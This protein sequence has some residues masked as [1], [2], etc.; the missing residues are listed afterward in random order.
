MVQIGHAL[1]EQEFEEEQHHAEHWQDDKQQQ[2]KP[3][4]DPR[5]RPLL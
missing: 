3:A 4:L 5:G 2:L 1:A